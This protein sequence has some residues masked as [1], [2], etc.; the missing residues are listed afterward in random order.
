MKKPA[1]RRAMRRKLIHVLAAMPSY[2]S[3]WYLKELAAL[4]PGTPW[5]PTAEERHYLRSRA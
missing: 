3:I 1:R 4:V 5:Y 2:V